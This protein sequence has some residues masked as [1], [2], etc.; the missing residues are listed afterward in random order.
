MV[1]IYCNSDRCEYDIRA[2]AMAFFP[3]TTLNYHIGEECDT[4][5]KNISIYIVMDVKNISISCGN[6][7]KDH[8]FADIPSGQIPDT[9]RYRDELKRLLYKVLKEATGNE[10]SWGTL[11]GVRP[12]KLALK[13]ILSG[14]GK[15]AAQDY[16]KREFFCSDAKAKLCTDVAVKEAEILE[17]IGFYKGYSVYIGIPFCPTVCTYCSFSSVS[18]KNMDKPDELISRYIEAVRKECEYVKKIFKGRKLTSIYVGGGTPTVLSERQLGQLMDIIC[19]NFDIASAEEFTV[20]AGRPDTIN[21]EKLAVLKR[22]GVTR[23][24]VNPQSMNDNTL[25]EIGRRHTAAQT[26][27]AYE[28]ARNAGFDNINMDII[29]GLAAEDINDF[30]YTLDRICELQPDSYTVHSLVVKRAS[31]YRR[32]KETDGIVRRRGGVQEQMLDAAGEYAQKYGYSPYYM[33]RQKNK[34]GLSESPVLENVGYAKPG[35]E[36]VYNIIIMEEKQTVAAVGAG[37]Q[38]KLVKPYDPY[39]GEITGIIRNSNVKNVYEY[40]DRIDEM[41]ERKERWAYGQGID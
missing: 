20:E 32:I 19:S 16:M 36:S 34:A 22:A 23:I 12:A 2:L 35:K 3:Y 29:A 21:E 11:T 41:I 10:L 27:H 14:G 37:A 7:K 13:V 25:Y 30:R 26:V 8:A 1:N 15:E 5:D 24:S 31:E 33:Y 6:I 4:E 17:R 38:S 39:S 40:I 28:L 9:K 18:L